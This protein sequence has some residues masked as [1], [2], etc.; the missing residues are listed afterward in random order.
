MSGSLAKGS[1]IVLEELVPRDVQ[2][3]HVM[4]K[5]GTCLMGTEAEASVV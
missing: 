3:G 5:V 1:L 2:D 4:C